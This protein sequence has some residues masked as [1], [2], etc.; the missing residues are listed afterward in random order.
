[1]NVSIGETTVLDPTDHGMRD[2]HVMILHAW[3]KTYGSD[4]VVPTGNR[5]VCLITQPGC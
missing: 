3:R 4:Y 1:M 2:T 5:I